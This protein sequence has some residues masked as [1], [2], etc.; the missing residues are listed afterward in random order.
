MVLGYKALRYSLSELSKVAAALPS[1]TAYSKLTLKVK[2]AK[3][4]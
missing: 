3:N 2:N 4:C 1:P